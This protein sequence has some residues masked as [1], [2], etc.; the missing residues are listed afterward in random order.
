MNSHRRSFPIRRLDTE[1]QVVRQLSNIFLQ[2]LKVLNKLKN[3]LE[4]ILPLSSLDF[5]TIKLSPVFYPFIFH[6]LRYTGFVVFLF[7][8]HRLKLFFAVRLPVLSP[9]LFFIS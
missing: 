7:L 4:N 1:K 8:R 2:P 5:V 6:T 9:M 3:T